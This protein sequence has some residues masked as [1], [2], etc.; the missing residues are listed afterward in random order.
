MNAEPKGVKRGSAI[1]NILQAL[2]N[3]VFEDQINFAKAQAR[4]FSLEE[5]EALA[6]VKLVN[7]P[8][9]APFFGSDGESEVE[10]LGL[11]QSGQYVVGRIDRMVK[12]E[13]EIVLID[14]KSD[15]FVPESIGLDHPY[16]RQISLY[17]D[18]MQSAF[19]THKVK[20]ALL[21]TQ[22]SYLEW[23]PTLSRKI[24]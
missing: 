23:I 10:I 13:T 2:P 11:H 18:L 5:S 21:W 7:V 6:L 9:L 15:R 12:T 22:N 17:S 16:A 19:P 14:F 4:R 8:H 20:A 1:H 3:I 24:S